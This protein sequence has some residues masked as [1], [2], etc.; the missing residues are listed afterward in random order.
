MHDAHDMELDT[1]S[2]QGRIDM[3]NKDQ[4]RVFSQISDHLLHQCQHE[5]K[6]C[7]CKDDKLLHMFVRNW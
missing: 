3:L 5:L 1:I 4:R 2:L 7:T 6:L